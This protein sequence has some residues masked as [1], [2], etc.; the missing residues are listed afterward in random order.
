MGTIASYVRRHPMAAYFGLTFVISWGGTLLAIGSG[1]GMRGTTPTS[2][3][4]F[5]YAV[6]AMLAG[7]SVTGIA[8]TAMA[9][10]RTGLGDYVERLL[11]WRVAARW[12]L[13]GLLTAPALMTATLLLLSVGSSAYL[14]GVVTSDHKTSLLFVS[15]AVGL[16]AGFFE[17]LGWTGFAIPAVR[18]HHG[19]IGTGLIVGI[20]WSAWHLLPNLWS[21]GAA[22]GELSLSTYLTGTAVAVFIGY[23]TAFRLFMVWVYEHTRSL[24][25]AMLMHVSLTA[26]LLTLNPLNLAGARLQIYSFAFAAVVWLV[27]ALVVVKGGSGR[28]EGGPEDGSSPNRAPIQRKPTHPAGAM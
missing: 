16:S 2:D 24:L 11:R 14:P 13:A 27:T 4:R 26:S 5:A 8:L 17:E 1:G 22:A 21:S 20:W 15:L 12:Y 7:P 10:G 6:L 28:R 25:L 18:R 9:S 23:L 3:P 19:I